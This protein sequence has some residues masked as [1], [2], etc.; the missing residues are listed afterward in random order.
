MLI[1]WRLGP[2]IFPKQSVTEVG[3]NFFVKNHPQLARQNDSQADRQRG[4]ERKERREIQT[5][6]SHRRNAVIS[7][8]IYFCCFVD[9]QA[10]ASLIILLCAVEHLLTRCL[11]HC[12]YGTNIKE[13]TIK[14]AFI[15]FYKGAIEH[16][17]GSK[18]RC[19]QKAKVSFVASGWT[20]IHGK[21]FASALYSTL[22]K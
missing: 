13:S 3:N 8:V 22:A 18:G 15:V 11:V 14:C 16:G 7:F 19:L 6:A 17:S 4:R 12:V 10:F 1:G 21:T 5:L 2:T 20:E 9:R